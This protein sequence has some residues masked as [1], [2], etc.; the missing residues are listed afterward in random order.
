MKYYDKEEK[1]L[2][3]SV[4]KGEWQPI[5]N[6]EE[7]KKR[8]A[9]IFKASSRKSE[10]VTINLTKKDLRELKIKASIEGLPYQTLIGSVLHKYVTG[11]FVEERI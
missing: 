2:I 9:G 5:Q 3:E 10:R 11:K 6:L 8:Y 7:E 4:E 1:E